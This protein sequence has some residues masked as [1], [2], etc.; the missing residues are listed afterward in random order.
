M[1]KIE[2]P[3]SGDVADIMRRAEESKDP[4]EAAKL[5]C[6]AADLGDVEAWYRLGECYEKGNGVDLDPVKGAECFRKIDE[7]F[8]K[9]AEEGD[10]DAQYSL[11]N[12][13]YRR[14]FAGVA[15]AASEA[16]KWL[17]KAAEQGNIHAIEKLARLP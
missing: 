14:W 4:V 7:R 10:A 2:V 15:E 11:G 8:R 13:Y 1:E 17:G 3:Y 12:F 9:A 16:K 6:E 5:F